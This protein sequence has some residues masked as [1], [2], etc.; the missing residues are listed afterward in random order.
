MSSHELSMVTLDGLDNHK[1]KAFGF[2]RLL[3][4]LGPPAWALYV[5]M[6][7]NS[8]QSSIAIKLHVIQPVLSIL[9]SAILQKKN[10]FSKL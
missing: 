9:I 10:S 5:Y 4:L 8:L 6:L 3:V 1:N 2:T 7:I